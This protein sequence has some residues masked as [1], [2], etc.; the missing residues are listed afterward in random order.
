MPPHPRNT[1][2]ELSGEEWLYFTKAVVQT[3]FV[4]YSHSSPVSSLSV[5]R[6]CGSARAG[7]S[8]RSSCVIR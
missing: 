5:L 1:L 7:G 2:N 3:D 8:A 6:G 4:K